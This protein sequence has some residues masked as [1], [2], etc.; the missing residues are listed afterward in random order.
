M[1]PF[2]VEILNAGSVLQLIHHIPHFLRL[3]DPFLL[4]HDPGQLDVILH[5]QIFHL[6]L[7][8]EKHLPSVETV[9]P[10]VVPGMVEL[11][12]EHMVVCP[13]AQGEDVYLLV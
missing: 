3:V 11:P 9:D 7:I 5:L 10:L 6:L 12:L 1:V 4:Y 13:C 8:L 2:L